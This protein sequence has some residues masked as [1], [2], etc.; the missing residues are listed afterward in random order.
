[1]KT[2]LR[3]ALG[4]AALTALTVGAPASA[5]DALPHAPNPLVTPTAARSVLLVRPELFFV[6]Q[7]WHGY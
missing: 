2:M 1:M 6:P 3:Y 4:I 7:G 5:T